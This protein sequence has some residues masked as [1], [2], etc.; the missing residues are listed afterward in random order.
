MKEFVRP[1]YDQFVHTYK[2]YSALN[3]PLG[4]WGITNETLMNFLEKSQIIE[5]EPKLKANTVDTCFT[6]LDKD[7]L[8]LQQQQAKQSTPIDSPLSVF[9]NNP[10]KPQ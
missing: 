6:A 3:P 5:S 9:L 10:R 1:I 8:I 7:L 2:H 4:L